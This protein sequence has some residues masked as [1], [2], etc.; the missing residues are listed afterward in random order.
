M[1]GIE[2]IIV[3]SGSVEIYNEEQH[4]CGLDQIEAQAQIPHKQ[5][6]VEDANVVAPSAEKEAAATALSKPNPARFSRIISWIVE[7]LSA[8]QPYPYTEFTILHHL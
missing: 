8:S 6:K 7:A 2:Q 1:T 5:V 3:Q 4:S